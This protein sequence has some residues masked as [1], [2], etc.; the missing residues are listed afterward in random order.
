MPSVIALYGSRLLSTEGGFVRWLSGQGGAA[1]R[2][3]G[4]VH[5]KVGHR[6]HSGGIP[7]MEME[8]EF[9]TANQLA[10]S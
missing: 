9:G 8:W 5:C 1:G 3:A 10:F 2:L 6:V 7:G 4:G